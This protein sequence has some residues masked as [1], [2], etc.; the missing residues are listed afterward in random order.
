MR[1]NETDAGT[2]PGPRNSGS[3]KGH[4]ARSDNSGNVQSVERAFWLLETMADNGGTMRLSELASACGLA[5]PTIHRLIRT[6]VDLGYLRQDAS[7]RYMLAPRLIGLGDSAA[8]MLAVFARPHLARLV[9]E[10]EETA[11]LAMLDSDQ[12]VYVAQV[13]SRHSMRMSTEVGRRV[14]A[15]ATAVGKAIMSR[16]PRDEV[17]ELIQRTGLAA[18]TEHTITDVDALLA[19]LDAAAENGYA[20]EDGERELGVRDVAVAVENAPARLAVSVSGPAVRMTDE[21]VAR[22]V[23]LLA[24]VGRTLSDDLG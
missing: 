10:L 23:P 24:D 20:L 7:R 16:L 1:E 13:P 11:N 22:A 21:W 15:H 2:S 6:L 4:S 3:A 19:Q 9:D 5:L 8:Q 18:K 12:I 17:R 14:D